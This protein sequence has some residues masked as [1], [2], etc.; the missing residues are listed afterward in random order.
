[1]MLTEFADIIDAEL[2]VCRYSNQGERWTAHFN[3]FEI[4]EDGFLLSAY[5]DGSTPIEALND[6]VRKIKGK[7]IVKDS[8]SKERR[9]E[10]GVPMT[11]TVA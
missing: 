2:M 11:L 10:Y 4:K 7:T 6:Y 9:R 3:Q 8:Y 5:G 1:M